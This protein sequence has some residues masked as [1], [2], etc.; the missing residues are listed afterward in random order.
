[1][2][3]RRHALIGTALILTVSGLAAC[4]RKII[5]NPA[6]YQSA[7]SRNCSSKFILDYNTVSEDPTPAMVDEFEKR[8]QSVECDAKEATLR[9]V[10][11]DSITI[12][13]NA[14]I[15][16]WRQELNRKR[17]KAALASQVAPATATAP[18]VEVASVETT[19]VAVENPKETEVEKAPTPCTEQFTDDAKRAFV[20]FRNALTATLMHPGSSEAY[21]NA[22]AQILEMKPLHQG[23]E[24]GNPATDTQPKTVFTWDSTINIYLDLLD[25]GIKSIDKDTKASNPVSLE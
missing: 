17:Q 24:C 21:V 3:T 25:K 10:E 4:A 12:S 16:T 1:M 23:V 19:S 18:S 8:Y 2:I 15:K 22:R 5:G 13:V 6:A 7:S 20:I 14:K 11:G 9:K